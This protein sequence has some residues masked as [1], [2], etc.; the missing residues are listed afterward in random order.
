MPRRSTPQSREAC[1]RAR[2]CWCRPRSRRP[3]W[4]CARSTP[5]ARWCATRS[6]PTATRCALTRAPRAGRRRG[7]ARR[8][9]RASTEVAATESDALALD[10]RRA[11]LEHALAVLVG[12]RRLDFALAGADWRTALPVD[13]GR[14]CPSTVL[15]RR[16]D[17]SAAQQPMLAAQARVGVAQAAWFP[18]LA[19]TA[20]GGYAS[21]DLGD[22][23]KWSARA[24][25]IGALLVAADLRR[26]PARGR[27]AERERR[28]STARWRSYR[29]QVLVAFKDV[30]DQLVALRL[31]AEQAD[32]QARRWRRRAARPRCRTR[33]TATACQPA[34]PAR[35]PAQR[36]AQPAPG[37]AGALG[38]IPG[39]PSGSS[40]R[41][42]AA[43]WD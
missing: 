27:R 25:G 34:R 1:C 8:G 7:R 41:F 33:A 19:L 3:I 37:A 12:D 38:A 39:P 43:G 18:R 40:G 35:R 2:G 5:S 22:L 20:G 4:R 9:A 28:S 31:L 16:P 26:R 6:T 21:T 23:F 30:E 24:W 17:V 36:A 13:P 32:A 14:A 42:L 11:E 29:E 15:T 10:R